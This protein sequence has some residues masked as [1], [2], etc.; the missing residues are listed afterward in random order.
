[1]DSIYEKFISNQ[2]KAMIWKLLIDD[3]IF[4]SIPPVN[5]PLIQKDFEKKIETIAKNITATDTLV[6]LDKRV[7]EEMLVDISAFNNRDKLNKIEQ[8][9]NAEDLSQKRQKIFQAEL[10]TKKKEFD[11]YNTAPVPNKIDFSDN[12]DSPMGGEMDKILA[13]QIAL[14]ESQLN[15]V[16][17]T[18]DKEAANKWIQNP[19]QAPQQQAQ[20]QQAQQQ[21]EPIKLKIEEKPKKV[22]FSDTLDFATDTLPQAIPDMSDDFMALFKKKDEP[23]ALLREILAKQNQILDLLR[24]N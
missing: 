22:I 5:A 14:R 13:A 16:L 10:S 3:G 11:T 19:G 21:Q 17:K 2:N 6:N 23:I 9:Y 24:K 1:M 12:L 18:Q 15:M 4:R 8:I 20:Q 7:I